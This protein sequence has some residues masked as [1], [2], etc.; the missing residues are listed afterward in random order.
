MN[1]LYEYGSLK[2]SCA[3]LLWNWSDLIPWLDLGRSLMIS[4]SRAL[5][6]LSFEKIFSPMSHNGREIFLEYAHPHSL[7]TTRYMY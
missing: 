6:E 5:S 1:Q 4:F 2:V 3:R 7:W